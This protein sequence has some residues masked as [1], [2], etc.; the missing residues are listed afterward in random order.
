[1]TAVFSLLGLLAAIMWLITTLFPVRET[2]TDSAVVAAISTAVA[3]VWPGAMV[4]KIEEE[5]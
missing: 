3:A 2:R 4:T 1:M 5:R